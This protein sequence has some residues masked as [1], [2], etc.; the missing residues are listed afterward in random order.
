MIDSKRHRSRFWL[1]W[2]L[3]A[4]SL[5]AT[6][7]WFSVP[8]RP[9]SANEIGGTYV[10]DC[11]FVHE[12]VV[13]KSNGIYKQAVTIK[14]TGETASSDGRWTFDPV[15]CY[16]RFDHHFMKT[17]NRPDELNPDYAHPSGDY[18]ASVEYWLGQLTIGGS[19]H[20]WPGWRRVD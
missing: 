17:L 18:V 14:A 5:V 11:D 6:C 4:V 3:L 16:V 15:N 13:V 19:P 7:I 2:L 9:K 12:V 20:P 1:L 8:R 10:L